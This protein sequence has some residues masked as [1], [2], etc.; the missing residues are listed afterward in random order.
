[1]ATEE[2]NGGRQLYEKHIGA[3]GKNYRGLFILVGP[4]DYLMRVQESK[5]TSKKTEET[6]TE[7]AVQRMIKLR[8][9]AKMKAAEKKAAQDE[10]NTWLETGTVAEALEEKTTGKGKNAKTMRAIEADLGFEVEKYYEEEKVA[11]KTPLVK[12]SDTISYV[13]VVDVPMYVKLLG[14]DFRKSLINC[15]NSLNK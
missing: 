6:I 5:V 10:I 1:M 12:F 4:G 8:P 2:K 7:I 3:Y 9:F 15:I 13:D 11:I 14:K